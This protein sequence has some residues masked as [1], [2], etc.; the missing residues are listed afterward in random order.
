MITITVYGYP[1]RES[2]QTL[3]NT[4]EE[5]KG[6][7][8][9]NVLVIDLSQD[10]SMAEYLGS[11][12]PMAQ[13][14]PYRLKSPIHPNDIKV[15]I[16]A[17][18]D[19]SERL[20]DD[21]SYRERIDRG[22]R[23]SSSD[24]FNLWISKNFAWVFAIIL[25]L[26]TGLAVLAPV[27]MKVDMEL[28]AKVLYIFYKPFCHQLAFRSFFL[29]GE[30]AYYPRELAGIEG[31]ITYE[32]LI[33]VTGLGEAENLLDSRNFLGNEFTGYKTALCQRCL[34]IYGAMGL[35]SVA[36]ALSGNKIKPPKWYWWIIIGLG[37][38]GLDGGSQIPGMLGINLPEWMVIRESV[39]LFR[40]VTGALFGLMTFWYLLPQVEDSMRSTRVNLMRKFAYHKQL[41]KEGIE[42]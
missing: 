30:Q 23:I 6:D 35:F 20:K 3:L 1:G 36:Y 13:V 26:Y 17:A 37:P 15:A 10:E 38:I 11:E 39:P 9:V 29:F 28:P 2:T 25:F 18:N 41:E 12:A 40:V 19:R 4:I 42:D 34:A 31:V 24:K 21:P 32:E 5:Q 8:S 7:V 16:T 33:E 22:R 27:L 14:G